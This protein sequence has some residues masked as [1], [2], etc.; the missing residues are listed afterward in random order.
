MPDPVFI[1]R[2][3]VY[4]YPDTTRPALRG[5]TMEMAAG[6]L[7]TVIGPNGAGKS[8]LAR[9]LA[10]TLRPTTGRVSFLGRP[11]ASWSRT[12]LARRLAVVAQEPPGVIP[13][14]VHE[15]VALGRNPYVSPWA[16][17]GAHDRR[18]VAEA[19]ERVG[20][21]ELAGRGLT[22][23]S[24]GELQRA[25]LARALAQEPDVLIIDEPTAHLD[26]GHALSAFESIAELV[27]TRGISALCITHDMNLA[28]RYGDE[29]ILMS[30]GVATAI[31]TPHEVL[32]PAALGT[33]Y[34]CTVEV[35]DHGRAGHIVI[36]VA[37]PD[38]TFPGAGVGR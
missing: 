26:M 5:I 30:D 36:P 35:E 8:T 24:G 29:V 4:L 17:L 9:L 3:V 15:Y 34:G 27:R 32:T 2:D 6:R 20:L 19:I 25:K 22:E 10:G 13:Q 1:A 38:A 21:A 37:A 12:D 7:T 11:L 28:S 23:L 16:S 33:A 18:V 14:S 31:G